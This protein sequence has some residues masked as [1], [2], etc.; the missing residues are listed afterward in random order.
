VPIWH[1][2]QSSWMACRTRIALP[3]GGMVGPYKS[4]KHQQQP[5]KCQ[6]QVKQHDKCRLHRK[7]TVDGLRD[8]HRTACCRRPEARGRHG[9]A[10]QEKHAQQRHQCHWQWQALNIKRNKLASANQTC[11]SGTCPKACGWLAGHASHC[12]LPL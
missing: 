12:M 5:W 1:M 11:Q 7:A 6:Q 3:G 9:G 8:M 4:C 2:S 10:L